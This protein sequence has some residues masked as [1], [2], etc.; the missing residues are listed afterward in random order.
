MLPG[1]F[2]LRDAAKTAKL[3]AAKEKEDARIAEITVCRQNTTIQ[4]LAARAVWGS[5]CGT[6][7]QLG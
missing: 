6:E 7:R 4:L 2:R 3:N 5:F 1:V